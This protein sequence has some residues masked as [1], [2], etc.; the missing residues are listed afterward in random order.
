MHAIGDPAQLLATLGEVHPTMFFGVPRVWEKIKTGLSAKLAADPDNRE[1]VETA[2]AAALAWVEA[3]EV[4]GVMT[5]E[6]EEAYRQAEEGILGF[7]KLLLGLDQV[8]WAGSAAAPMPLDVAKFMAG[9]G[10]KVYDVYGMTETCG[11]VT[12]NGPGGFKL[13]TVGRANPGMEIKLGEDGE[14]LVRGPVNTPGYHL[15]EEATRALIDDDG[16]L[17]TGDIGTLDDDGFFA[18]VDRK[19]ELI[20]TSA[21]KNVA[22]SNIE[23]FL[24]ES[25]LIG[26]AMAI[27]DSRPVRR[28]D[29]HPRRRDRADHGPADGDRVHRPG[30]PR[31]EAG[32]PGDR[33][34]GR[35]RRQRAALAPRAGQVVRAAR[36]R[37]DR[38][39]R[40]AHPDAQAQAPGG[41]H[42]VLRRAWTASTADRS[43]GGLRKDEVLSRNPP[44]FET[45]AAQPPQP[46][47]DGCCATSSTNGQVKMSAGGCLMVT[48]HEPEGATPMSLNDVPGEPIW[49]ELFT[50][51]TES[52]KTFYGELFGWTARDAGEEFGGYITF[53]RDGQEIAGCMRNDGQAP[54]AWTVY[55]ESNN[56]SDTV[57]MA[58]ANGGQVL[59]EPMQVGDFGHMA[60]VSDPAGAAVGVW[61]PIEMRGISARAEV[62]APGWFEVLSNDYDSRDPVLRE[63][64]RV[65]HPH[66]ER[67]PRVPLHDARHRT[68]WR[69]PGSWMPAGSWPGAP[70]TGSFYIVVEDTDATVAAAIE[71]G[72]AQLMEPEESPFGRLATIAD[73]S[74]V[75]FMVMGPNKGASPRDESPA[76]QHQRRPHQ[77]RSDQ[78]RRSRCRSG[79]ACSRSPPSIVSG[80]LASISA[81]LVENGLT[82]TIVDDTASAATNSPALDA[83]VGD[84]RDAR[85]G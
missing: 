7:L 66:H 41:E 15:Q 73:P 4:G 44:G 38:R 48:D 85:S 12:A 45:V 6:I 31:R 82:S 36:R 18:V 51:D 20:I 28:R 52:A 57:A 14:I 68:T 69:W 43:P 53:E 56:A 32:D 17:H 37:V 26:H 49:I 24:K 60:V 75:Q 39:V 71:L 50:P 30:R 84:Q 65:E 42:Q 25:P 67:H 27:G 23:N 21:G 62:G 13:G 61:Q 3:Q 34:A 1:M 2:M 78:R 46:T 77:Q 35:R 5:P 64:L 11:A 83:A 19:K 63:R 8:T 22:P 9:L 81:P 70:H 29:P 40:G 59:L 33:P 16:W 10:L 58:R 72:G 55:L 74:G 47:V 79:S 76:G 54:N 80:L